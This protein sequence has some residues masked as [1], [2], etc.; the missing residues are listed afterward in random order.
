MWESSA[1]ALKWDVHI[2]IKTEGRWRLDIV[3]RNQTRT[4]LALQYSETTPSKTTEANSLKIDH[5]HFKSVKIVY[6]SKWPQICWLC[7]VQNDYMND[8]WETVFTGLSQVREKHSSRWRRKICWKLSL[9]TCHFAFL[10]KGNFIFVREKMRK[11][12]K[13]MNMSVATMCQPPR[14]CGNSVGRHWLE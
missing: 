7:N 4:L 8:V 1:S 5:L 6:S 2:E 9:L 14:F 12:W 13:R 11:F 3:L 10:C